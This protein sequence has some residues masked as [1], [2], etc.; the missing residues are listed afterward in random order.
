ML[1]T[2]PFNLPFFF[3]EEKNQLNFYQHVIYI[4]FELLSVHLPEKQP[5]P[6][7]DGI[8]INPFRIFSSFGQSSDKMVFPITNPPVK[9]VCSNFPFIHS[10]KQKS[11]DF[12]PGFL[13]WSK[14]ELFFESH[15]PKKAQQSG[16]E[17]EQGGGFG[18]R[19]VVAIG[20][21]ARGQS[22]GPWCPDDENMTG[23]NIPV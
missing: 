13:F 2:L 20:C 4:P 12:N 1:A 23:T 16:A 15:E 14:G 19:G 10:R 17:K 5:C 9:F 8:L 6:V 11:Q 22:P 7:C 21:K 18:N 3:N